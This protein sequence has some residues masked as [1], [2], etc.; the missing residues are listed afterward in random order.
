MKSYKKLSLA[1]LS[2]AA[3]SQVRAES[4]LYQPKTPWPI[5]PFEDAA[6]GTVGVVTLNHVGEDENAASGLAV[7]VP[8]AVPGVAYARSKDN[9]ENNSGE[10]RHHHVRKHNQKKSSETSNRKRKSSETSN[11]KMKRHSDDESNS[12]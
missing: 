1:L 7:A 12:Y 4:D 8:D 2:F 3:F 6:V 10:K 9:D 5:A 11:R